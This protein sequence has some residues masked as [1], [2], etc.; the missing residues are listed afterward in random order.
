[1][2]SWTNA[3]EEIIAYTAVKAIT[4]LED[5]NRWN[6]AMNTLVETCGDGKVNKFVIDIFKDLSSVKN[7]FTC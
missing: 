6:T 7:S 3:N 4:D 2:R 5:S 1:M